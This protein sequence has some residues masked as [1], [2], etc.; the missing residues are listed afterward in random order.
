P[1]AAAAGAG[2]A[3][4]ENAAKIRA[5]GPGPAGLAAPDELAMKADV[6]DSAIGP[7]TRDLTLLATVTPSIHVADM[8]S[9]LGDCINKVQN[10]DVP[11]LRPSFLQLK[12]GDTGSVSISGG[13]GNYTTQV[14]GPTGSLQVTQTSVGTKSARIDIAVPQ[15]TAPGSSYAVLVSDP[16]RRF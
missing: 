2:S 7:V 9:T 3:A 8:N 11:S 15:T 14:I 5:A 6:V 4:S 13:S 12:P 1:A 16:E 10:L